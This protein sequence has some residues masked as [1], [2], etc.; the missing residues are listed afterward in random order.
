MSSE[1]EE[2]RQR[3]LAEMMKGAT[4]GKAGDNGWPESP[5]T[6]SDADFDQVVSKYSQVVVDCWAPWCG[7]C[8]MLAP[9]IE[10]MAKDHKGKVVFAK[11]NTDDN[12]NTASKY[13]IMSIP[14]LLFFKDGKLVNKMVGAAPRQM[15][16]QAV[17]TAFNRDSG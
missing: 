5:V 6:V 12:F 15:L 8:R 10:S 2:I 16:E 3:K 9:T 13:R 1:I 14:T 11:L 4:E 7:P 17:Q